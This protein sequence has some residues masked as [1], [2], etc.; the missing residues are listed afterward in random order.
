MKRQIPTRHASRFT[1]LTDYYFADRRLV[2]VPIEHLRPGRRRATTFAAALT[3]RAGWTAARIALLDAGFALYWRRTTEL[4]RHT[5]TWAPPR[6][7]HIAVLREPLAVHPYAQLLNASAWTLYAS[8]LDPADSHA[9]LVAYLLAHG[10]RAARL[11]EVTMAALHNAA[12]WFARS[13]A[14]CDAFAAAA[15]AS[16]RPD[17]DAFRALADALPW[18]RRLAHARLRPA[19]ADR[20]PPHSGHRVARAA[21]RPGGA[22]ALGRPLGPRRARRHRYLRGDLAPTDAAALDALADWLTTPHR[23]C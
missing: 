13:D 7:R 10:D 3:A 11:G 14:E 6:L 12:W 19:P 15:A 18:L 2:L 9:E 21:G 23:R 20:L 1:T 8:D 5:A 4:A 22:A 16:G 17:A